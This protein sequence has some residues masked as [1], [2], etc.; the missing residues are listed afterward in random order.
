VL[1]HLKDRISYSLEK[2]VAKLGLNYQK[3]GEV[4]QTIFYMTK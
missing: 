4:I 2:M 3:Y 1:N